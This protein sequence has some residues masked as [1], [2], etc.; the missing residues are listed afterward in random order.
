MAAA[1]FAEASE[2]R[3]SAENM[4]ETSRRNLSLVDEIEGAAK[5]VAAWAVLMTGGKTTP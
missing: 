1:W 3:E 2:L 4:A 5:N